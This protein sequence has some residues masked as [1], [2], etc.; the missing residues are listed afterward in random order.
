[1]LVV[2]HPTDI[3]TWTPAFATTLPLHLLT[4]GRVVWSSSKSCFGC[5]VKLVNTLAGDVSSL[6]R[7][8]VPGLVRLD[9]DISFQ[10]PNLEG[11]FETEMLTPMHV[12]VSELTHAFE[13]RASMATSLFLLR[14]QRKEY[15]YPVS[16]L[17]RVVCGLRSGAITELVWVE[18]S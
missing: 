1:M 3:A 6:D 2:P 4:C 11:R 15:S 16:F 14:G 13:Y 12:E 10:D 9:V 5:V 17:Y 8:R 7:W 18:S